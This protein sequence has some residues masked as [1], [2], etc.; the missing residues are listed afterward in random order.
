MLGVLYLFTQILPCFNAGSA[1]PD[2]EKLKDLVIQS[3]LMEKNGHLVDALDILGGNDG[4]GGNICKQGDFFL[5]ALGEGSLRPAQEDI[6][7]DADGAQLLDTVLCRLGFYLAGGLDIRHKGHVNEQGIVAAD[8]KTEL[9]YSLQKRQPLNITD[10]AA[11]FYYG[12]I[13]SISQLQDGIFY[14]VSNVWYDLN[15]PP[16][17]LAAPFLRNYRIINAA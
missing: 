12:N 15:C 10:G 8:I 3:L 9:T 14:L 13:D 5:Q 1:C 17:V 2:I 16:Q 4:I 7:L 6:R 11:D